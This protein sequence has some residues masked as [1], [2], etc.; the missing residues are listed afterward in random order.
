MAEASIVTLQELIG[1]LEEL[2]EDDGWIPVTDRLP[3]E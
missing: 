2:P 3:E 1:R